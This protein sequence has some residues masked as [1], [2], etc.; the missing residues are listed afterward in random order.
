MA[1]GYLAGVTRVVVEARYLRGSV[2]TSACLSLE[3][4]DFG[5]QKASPCASLKCSMGC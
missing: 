2:R 3:I 4:R 5:F 1:R